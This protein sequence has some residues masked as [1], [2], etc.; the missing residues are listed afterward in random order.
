MIMVNTRRI[1]TAG[2]QELKSCWLEP[3][4]TGPRAAKIYPP[5][6]ANPDSWAVFQGSWPSLKRLPSLSLIHI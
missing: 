6:W 1:K 2:V 4:K 3:N 5:V